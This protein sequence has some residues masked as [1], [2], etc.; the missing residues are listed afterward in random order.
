MARHI[1]LRVPENMAEL[2]ASV[3]EQSAYLTKEEALRKGETDLSQNEAVQTSQAFATEVRKIV[4][5]V[6]LGFEVMALEYLHNVTTLNAQLFA[7]ALGKDRAPT[8]ICE[9]CREVILAFV[10]GDHPQLQNA[11][12]AGQKIV[13]SIISDSK[14]ED[15]R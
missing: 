7:E 12:E 14:N 10:A 6:K 15:S 5:E 8:R 11:F 3:C 2:I 1:F 13:D 9:N 4:D